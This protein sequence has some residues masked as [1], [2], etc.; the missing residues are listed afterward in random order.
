MLITTRTNLN[1]LQDAFLNDFKTR[2]IMAAVATRRISPGRA[3][4]K[5]GQN[6]AG[7]QGCRDGWYSLA[8]S[9]VLAQI[10]QS[11]QLYGTTAWGGA[12][13]F[14]RDY[15]PLGAKVADAPHKAAL[16][17]NANVSQGIAPDSVVSGNNIV[18][19]F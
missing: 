11:S 1:L 10:Q 16:R 7:N 3:A 8:T 2:Q 13:E 6:P 18:L 12:V 14:C 17:I 15:D 19:T 4:S 5:S 9:D